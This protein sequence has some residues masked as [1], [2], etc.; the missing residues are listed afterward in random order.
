MTR[1][2]HGSSMHRGSDGDPFNADDVPIT[3]AGGY[4]TATDVEGALQEIG[5]GGFG[6]GPFE[7]NEATS[8]WELVAGVWDVWSQDR[9]AYLYLD[10]DYVE[11]GNGTSGSF[12][13]LDA[14]AS[15]S[16]GGRIDLIA[17]DGLRV[18]RLDA[19]PG[20]PLDGDLYYNTSTNKF[21]GRANGA[22]VDLH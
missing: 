8:S 17:G 14:G 3:D 20:S 18:P 12:F 1:I 21:R 13:Y 22:W 9:S 16:V 11:I 15:L 7:W 6:S 19:D 4:F 5:G 10:T 2:T